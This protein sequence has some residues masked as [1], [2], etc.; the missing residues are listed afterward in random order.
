MNILILTDFFPPDHWGGAEISTF[1]IARRLIEKGNKVSVISSVQKKEKIGK[2]MYEGIVIYRIYSNYK[3]ILNE[4]VSL[5]NPFSVGIVKRLIKKI[6]PDIVQVHGVHIHLSYYV[7][8]IIGSLQIPIVLTAHDLYLICPGALRC[9]MSKINDKSNKDIYK[10]NA[11][12]CIICQ[13]YRHNPLRNF[14]IKKLVNRYVAETIVVSEE[15]K[16]ILNQNGFKNVT[17]IYNGVNLDKF[18][19]TEKEI[20]ETK[21]ENNLF[22]KKIIFSGGRFVERKGFECLVMSMVM[23]VDK[24]GKNVCLVLC[25]KQNLYAKYLGNLAKKMGVRDNIIFTGWLSGKDFK[26][27]LA[28]CNL[29]VI[30]SLYPDPLPRLNFEAMAAG[31][32]VIASCFGGSKEVV[33]NEVNGYIIDPY[34]T[35]EMANKI[36]HILRNPDIAGIMGNNGYE[37]VKFFFTV[38]NNVDTRIKL[39]EK[40][41]KNQL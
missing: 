20:E 40:I 12:K 2:I 23:L 18:K 6:K 36:M 10:I 16:K 24:F 27:F 41:L 17:V 29:V 15:L 32:P 9:S 39:Y 7:L 13:K 14:F 22:K 28:T 34:N 19:V 8:K 4:Y 31:K 11:F 21:K 37:K 26:K 1:L 30:P 35:N 33:E 25:G 5:F 3:M 38:E